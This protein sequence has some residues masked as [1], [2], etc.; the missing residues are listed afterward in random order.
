MPGKTPQ[1]WLYLPDD[2]DLSAL[3]PCLPAS[4]M[5]SW[6]RIFWSVDGTPPSLGGPQ[7]ALVIVNELPAWILRLQT[8]RT[9]WFAAND[10]LYIK[11]PATEF[12][13]IFFYKWV[14]INVII[15]ATG[16]D[17]L[18]KCTACLLELSWISCPCPRLSFSLNFHSEIL[19]F[20]TFPVQNS[21]K[22]Y[23][24]FLS[25]VALQNHVILLYLFFGPESAQENVKKVG[26][27]SDAKPRIP[28]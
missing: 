18:W 8:S 3:I 28:S 19:S 4:L 22:K 10:A 1:R 27:A 12:T 15:N 14:L 6:Y 26:Q 5:L 7:S 25:G 11:T 23:F 24:I 2:H 16:S 17:I 21:K 13:A 20:Y 9:M